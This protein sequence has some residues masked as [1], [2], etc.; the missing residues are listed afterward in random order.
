[1]IRLR[2]TAR[3]H[4]RKRRPVRTYG[5]PIPFTLTDLAY[6]ER[7]AELRAEARRYFQ[8]VRGPNT[9]IRLTESQRAALNIGNT[10]L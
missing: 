7:A 4:L 10:K 5:V 8:K 9:A 2:S 3:L 6:R 1:M